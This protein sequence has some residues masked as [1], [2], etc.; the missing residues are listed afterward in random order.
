M[1]SAIQNN[2]GLNGFWGKFVRGL[3]QIV[4]DAIGGVPIVGGAIKNALQDYIDNDSYWNWRVE[5]TLTPAERDILTLWT[6]NVLTPFITVLANDLSTALQNQNFAIQLNGI[7]LALRR[8]CL[9]KSYFLTSQTKGLSPDAVTARMELIT[10]VLTPIDTLIGETLATKPGLNFLSKSTPFSMAE[11]TG[12]I[13][14]ANSYSCNQYEMQK[15][16]S[17][18]EQTPISQTTIAEIA[19][20][21]TTATTTAIKNDGPVERYLLLGF[22][23]LLLIL[24]LTGEKD[25]KK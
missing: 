13:T 14:S 22:A 6:T 18:A 11:F 2:G 5:E 15:G 17:P 19:N 8:I 3:A 24:G 9:L 7:N 16:Q 4:N 21:G 10:E 20:T 25:K 1:Y 23:A 12:I